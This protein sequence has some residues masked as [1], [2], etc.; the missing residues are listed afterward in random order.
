MTR[1]IVTSKHAVY[2]TAEDFLGE[3]VTFRVGLPTDWHTAQDRWL[4]LDDQRRG[5]GLTIRYGGR[6]YAAH[7]CEVRSVDRHGRGLGSQRHAEA[8]NVP[9][10]IVRPGRPASYPWTTPKTDAQK[11][12]EYHERIRLTERQ[13]RVLRGRAA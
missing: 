11:V 10:K 12:R 7:A 5:R 1:S 3:R 6:L 9:Y 13:Q 4:R 2:V 8:V